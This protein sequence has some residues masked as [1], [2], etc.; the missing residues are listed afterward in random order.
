MVPSV[1]KAKLSEI[2]LSS[3]LQEWPYEPGRIQVRRING[4]DGRPKIQLRVE[5]GVLQ[6]E[7]HGRPDGAR[8]EGMESLLDYQ[9]DRI[10]RY[11]KGGGAESNFAL[12]P[13][14]CAAMRDESVLYYHRYV[15]MFVLEEYQAVIRDTTRNLKV[16]DLCKNHAVEEEDRRSME[17]FRPYVLMM[18]TRAEASEAIKNQKPKIA[19]AVLDAGLELI[20]S[21]FEEWGRAEDYESANE[22]MLLRGMREI[23]VPK[24]PVS[25]H[26]ELK[27]RLKAAID[28]ENYEL[29]AILRDELRQV[30]PGP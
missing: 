26:Y 20:K 24:L 16:F 6:M 5:L 11:S 27:Q 17:Q 23:L 9:L 28:A 15:A 8:P 14:E 22:V 12:S 7:E 30:D 29:A 25:E 21:V 1:R 13:A 3:L 10:E 4:L 2:D 19:L 18:R